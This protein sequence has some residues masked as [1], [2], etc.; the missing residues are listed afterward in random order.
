LINLQPLE[1][2]FLSDLHEA[3]LTVAAHDAGGA[4]V[5]E[6]FL[7]NNNL[8]VAHHR[9]A[10]P[11]TS[12]L[13]YTEEKI[14]NLKSQLPEI[15]LAGTGWQTNFEINTISQS[16]NQ[17]RRTI[18]FLDHW[19]NFEQRLLEREVRIEVKE[20]VTFD[21]EARALAKEIFPVSIV[22]LF[23]NYYLNEQVLEICKKRTPLLDPEYDILFIGEPIRN[24]RYSEKDAFINTMRRIRNANLPRQVIAVRPHPSQTRDSYI[25]MISHY[26]EFPIIVTE[27]TTLTDDL[28]RSKSVVGCNSMA[29]KLA[30][31]A[32]IPVYSAVPD[33]YESDLPLT[34]FQDW[35]K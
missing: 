25:D 1:T 21:E 19:T 22:Y 18:V 29:I 16:I 13:G 17:N 35:F 7:R 2:K 34:L 28:S 32:G 5:L 14:R 6:A 30:S 20:I 31:L 12:I 15:L 23:P 11:A 27:G 4:N 33:P 26:S 8:V 9:L 10:G 24:Q 3:S